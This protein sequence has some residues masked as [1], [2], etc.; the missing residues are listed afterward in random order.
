M[1]SA[2]IE[3]AQDLGVSGPDN[4]YGA[5]LINLV[6]AYEW[7]R[8]HIP[9]TDTVEIIKTRYHAKQR[10]L[11]VK[12][13]SDAAPDVTLTLPEYGNVAMVYKA[14]KGIYEKVVNNVLAKPAT[15][16]VVSSG[17]GSDTKPVPFPKGVT[18]LETRYMKN[19][20]EL[21]V[22]AISDAQPEAILRLPRYG[23][24]HMQYDASKGYYHIVVQNVRKAPKFV[25]VVSNGKGR[26]TRPV[27][28]IANR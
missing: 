22:I 15:V 16:T 5:G 12:A 8:T 3:T 28:Y 11:V 25:T 23:N 21:L 18:I 13:A 26:D 14:R 27:P 20:K 24:V 1:E 19:T 10:Q 17:G 4:D 6:A 7:L 9:S 2:I